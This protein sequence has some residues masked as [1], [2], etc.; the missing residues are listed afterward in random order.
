[1][2]QE[3][4]PENNIEN[5]HLTI[6]NENVV[7]VKDIQTATIDVKDV[8]PNRCIIGCTGCTGCISRVWE[9]ICCKTGCYRKDSLDMRCCGLNCESTDFGCFPTLFEFCKSPLCITYTNTP[10]SESLP[11]DDECCC[12]LCCCPFK[13]VITLPCLLGSAF[14]NIINCIRGTR[15]NYLC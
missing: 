13:F 14:N 8:Q 10:N 7:M 2:A 6:I 9:L 1:M 12:A 11:G 5:N 3:T 15:G 4:N